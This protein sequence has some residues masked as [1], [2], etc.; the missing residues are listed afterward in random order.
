MAA[1]TSPQRVP[2]LEAPAVFITADGAL[3]AH[4]AEWPGFRFD[5]LRPALQ[6]DG[7]GVAL[8][9]AAAAARTEH[10][11]TGIA[12]TLTLAPLPDAGFE[13]RPRLRAT[14]P[15]TL[16][17]VD[18]LAGESVGFGH[19]PAQ[20]RVLT[21]SRYGGD[22]APL[23]RPAVAAADTAGEPNQPAAATEPSTFASDDVMV[24]YD[25]A[26]GQALLLG[27]LA[28]ER[29][30]GEI[31]LSVSPDG[32][33]QRLTAGCDGGDL[34]L[35]PGDDLA[36][37]PLAL[38]RGRDPWA[39]LERYGELVRERHGVTCPTVPPVSWCSWYPY[40]LGV[41]EERLLAEACIAA[42]RL[43]PL[44]LSIIEAD[45]GWEREHLPNAFEPNAKFAHGLAWLARQLGTL[46]F[47]LGVWKAPYTIS[48]FDELATAHPDWLVCDDDGRPVSVWTWFWEPHGDVYILDIT[49]PGAQQWLRE[50][51]TTLAAAGVGYFKADFIGMARDGRAK[52]RHDARIVAGGGTEAARLGA[53]IL[54]DA[55]PDA[56]FLNCGGPPLPGTG[57]W[58]L[59]YICNDTGNTGLLAWEFARANFRAVACHLW[60]NRRWGIIQPSCLC[61][62]LPG[63]LEEARLR[64]TVA[65]LAGGQVDISDTLSTLPEDRWQVL[66]ATLPPLGRSARPVDLFEPVHHRQAA[67]YEALCRGQETAYL[68]R[69]HPPASVWHLLVEH[70]WE[71][72]DLVA[73]FAF[74][75]PPGAERAQMTN[76]TIQLA[77]LGLDARE[78]YWAYEFW[79]G[80]FLGVLPG[81]RTNPG[82]YAHPGDW[83]DLLTPGPAAT[84]S[85]SYT[86]PGVKLLA[87]RR[88]RRHP[89]VVGTSFHQ[90]CGTE[91]DAVA[92]D[93]AAG[94]LRGILHRPA[95]EQGW[96]VVV[97]GAAGRWALSSA[98]QSGRRVQPLPAAHGAW[99]LPLM[100]T[101]RASAWRC[102]F[103]RSPA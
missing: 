72:W 67:D 10:S 47:R 73:C 8:T 12:L 93:E 33:V 35:E 38:L 43:R 80:Q 69:E 15:G 23:R 99:R 77:R 94:E 20:V 81:A 18:L 25:R 3:A 26:A 40:R 54:R 64:A 41:T 50:R 71:S 90:S 7:R 4:V 34:R 70:G 87:L 1:P 76:F 29:W 19:D 44:G 42:R 96:L 6:V 68:E 48:A 39:L 62:G 37:E 24:I 21:L 75:Q 56:L 83:Q 86:G 65:F 5:D 58:P 66:T 63:T 102:R 49:H 14:A 30:Q 46:G 32:Q 78:R 36:L 45:L 98:A 16:T 79:S 88:V 59:L 28:S 89:W 84:L 60:Q 51:A 91:L 82:G 61:V 95:G 85:L 100:G 92:W 2:S 13:L 52:R 55:I 17:R 27:F 101:G 53:R 11:A 103:R 57:A 9:A 22:V 31:R 97:P 74:D